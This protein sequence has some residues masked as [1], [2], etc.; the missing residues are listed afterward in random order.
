MVTGI[1]QY[2]TTRFTKKGEI[3]WNQKAED[4]N[5]S[6]LA[7]RLSTLRLKS[8]KPPWKTAKDLIRLGF[9]TGK[10]WHDEWTKSSIPN[11]NL[12]PGPNQ[13]VIGTELPR[14]EW[15]VIN[16]LRTVHGYCADI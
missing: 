6:L 16:R 7:E 10:Y 2:S 13:G 9:E 8:R 1:N 3:C 12:V 11:N 14:H 4:T 15:S 5:S